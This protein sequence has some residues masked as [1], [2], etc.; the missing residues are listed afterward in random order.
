MLKLLAFVLPLGLDSFAVAA[1]IGASQ[2]TTVRQRLRISLIFVVFEGG[3]PLI[4]LALGAA[5]ARGI[6]QVA[7]Y[8]AGGAVIGIGVW[9]LLASDE[10]E[11]EKASRLTGSRGLPLIAPAGDEPARP[12]AAGGEPAGPTAAGAGLA[13][14]TPARAELAGFVTYGPS[15]DEDADPAVGEVSTIYVLAEAWGRGL[16][17]RLMAGAVQRLTGAG[18]AQATLWVLRTNARARRFYA[19]AGWSEDG[20]ALE[21]ASPGFPLAEVRYRRRLP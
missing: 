10:D 20:A 21:D 9:M 11:E 1:A 6:G 16:G 4:G 15:R 2:V 17:R 14:V 18:Y 5:L 13:G 12:T 8:V 3:M 7:D 19:A